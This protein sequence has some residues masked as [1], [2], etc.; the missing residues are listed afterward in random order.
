MNNEQKIKRLKKKILKQKLII[1]SLTLKLLT[2]TKHKRR[3]KKEKQKRKVS[4]DK[5]KRVKI[6]LDLTSDEYNTKSE[7][8][9]KGILNNEII[10]N[11]NEKIKHEDN[12]IV[13]KEINKKEINKK[14]INKKEINKEEIH[15]EEII[16][17]IK[18]TQNIKISPEHIEKINCDLEMNKNQ[19]SRNIENSK[20][21]NLSF[22]IDNKKIS[23]LEKEFSKII[24]FIPLPHSG[25]KN[26][27]N[28]NDF[29]AYLKSLNIPLFKNHSF[30]TP[31]I[32]TNFVS[33]NYSGIHK[34]FIENLNNSLHDSCLLAYILARESDFSKKLLL[35]HDIILFIDNFSKLIFI[36]ACIF[37]KK[38]FD[39]HRST[40]LKEK[41]GNWLYQ[42]IRMIIENQLIIDKDL[43]SEPQNIEILEKIKKNY[44]LE[45]QYHDFYKCAPIF[46]SSKTVN[47][48]C[49]LRIVAHYMDW[50]WSYNHLIVDILYP[51][52]VLSKDQII[53]YLIGVV[54]S[55]GYRNIG[56]HESV[57]NVYDFLEKEGNIGLYFV[58]HIKNVDVPE[59]NGFDKNLMKCIF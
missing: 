16:N 32:L 12:D 31:K 13:R 5:S 21:L 42:T 3:E 28:F 14:E 29:I 57:R 33:I 58:R 40:E 48:V 41:N 24:E 26:N 20:T 38:T 6:S 17:N 46:A 2:I 22:L 56:L 35:F 10:K 1:E 55:N 11:K 52:Y 34:F 47:E 18:T 25:F 53:L 37:S 43:F 4:E 8:N 59:I 51:K 7:I 44:N 9:E 49:A 36:F 39:N 15:S 19:I 54:V 50:D 45:P 23:S 30:N 27:F